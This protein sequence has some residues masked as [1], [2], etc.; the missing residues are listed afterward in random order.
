LRRPS[1]TD[2][3]GLAGARVLLAHIGAD[4]IAA[5]SI[6]ADSIS[7]QL[8]ADIAGYLSEDADGWI[9]WRTVPNM[10]NCFEMHAVAATRK[11]AV[12]DGLGLSESQ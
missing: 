2:D 4:A 3:D 1:V 9:F 8:L 12:T 5:D 6:A 10:N 7:D 11:Q